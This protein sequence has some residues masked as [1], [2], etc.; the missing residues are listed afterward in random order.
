M[1]K[2][3]LRA[4]KLFSAILV[5][6]GALGALAIVLAKPPV[7]GPHHHPEPR[8]GQADLGA[9]VMPASFF[10]A[11]SRPA[12]AYQFAREIPSTLDGIYCYCVCSEALGHVSLLQCFESQHGAGC[13]VCMK[14]AEVAY[15][16]NRDG[17][18]LSEI[19]TTI[20]ATFG[21]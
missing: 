5:V 1:S 4:G 21:S 3:T 12:Q 7:R 13:D 8:V 11:S 14:E 10:P 20:D 16:M 6:A 17:R 18:T 19:R 9:A 2:V 15:Q